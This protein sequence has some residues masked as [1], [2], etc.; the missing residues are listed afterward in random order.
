MRSRFRGGLVCAVA[1]SLVLLGCT[2]EEPGDARPTGG[3]STSSAPEPPTSSNSSRPKEIKLDGLDPCQVLT[4]DQMKQLSVSEP[5]LQ[6]NDLS[7]L[8]KFPLCDYSSNGTPR[9]GYGV[10]L[11]TSKGIDHWQGNGNVDVERTEV[12]GYPA[13]QVV[14]S[15]TDNVM[16]SIAVD[17]ADGQQ[18]LVDFNPLADDYPQD[19]MCQNAKKAAELALVTL[20]TLV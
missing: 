8:G 19:K 4:T 3:G 14:L 11:V 17:V 12:S 9:F 15:G 10:G 20:P 7:G 13:A 18:L 16:C 1:A 5:D 6:E 2:A